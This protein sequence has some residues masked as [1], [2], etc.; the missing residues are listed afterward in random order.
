M[1]NLKGFIAGVITT[2]LIVIV[3]TTVFAKQEVKT[4]N[5]TYNNIK[6][7]IDGESVTL[8]DAAGN[9]VE[10]F[11]YNGTNYLP[12]RAIS[13]AVGYNVDWDSKTNTIVL[14]K[15]SGDST[16]ETDMPGLPNLNM[17]RKRFTF[18]TAGWGETDTCTDVV[19]GELYDY[20]DPILRLAKERQREIEQKYNVVLRRVNEGDNAEAVKMY[21]E[22]I[23]AGIDEYDVA[24]TNCTNFASLLSDRYMHDWEEVPYIDVNKPYWDRNFYDSMA[25]FG[26]HYALDGDITKRSLET[27]WIMAFNK[28]LIANNGLESPFDLVKHGEWTYDKM[29]EMARY[30]AQD[31]NGDGKMTL[32]DD[33]W[34]INYTGDSIMGIINSSGVNLCEFDNKKVP[35]LTMGTEV[36][37]AKL[38]R[39]YS[40]M[41]N[42]SYS[43]DTLFKAG[44]GTTDFR[45]AQIFSEGRCLF[46]AA[47]VGN[48]QGH[49]GYNLRET[50]VDFGIVP[51]PKWDIATPNYTR[52]TGGGNH[53]VLTIPSTNRD[54]ESTG[55]ILEAMAYLGSQTIIP[56]FYENLLKRK[57]ARDN[58]SRDMIDYIFGNLHYDIGNMYNFGGMVGTFGYSMSSQPTANIV[59]QIDKYYGPWKRAI[60][61]VVKS[62]E[63]NY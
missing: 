39:I 48:I 2:L 32:E 12:A 59:S 60:D 43:I 19:V 42:N 45:D 25:I 30:V 5:A 34:G 38:E 40:T 31:M 58:E 36:N 20:T 55:I 37:L 27:V 49:D 57:T 62:I 47:A 10:P 52:F 7:T 3:A 35:E 4:I 1:K 29:H 9:S 41:R 18:L 50:D 53:P 33:M 61:V 17:H 14:T 23:L 22:A 21:K 13:E 56:E 54:L 51:Y 16:P 15:K 28:N 63:A 6:V 8:K 11:L 24:I 44:G 46:L 26:K